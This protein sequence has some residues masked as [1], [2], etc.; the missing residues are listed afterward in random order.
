MI[1][2][3]LRELVGAAVREALRPLERE[4]RDL[5]ATV[6]TNSARWLSRRE[7]AEALGISTDTIDRQVRDGTLQVRRTGRAIRVLVAPPATD[8]EIAALARTV[9]R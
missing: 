1:E 5:R 3:L 6:A 7:A 8:E 4:V 9:R 2:E